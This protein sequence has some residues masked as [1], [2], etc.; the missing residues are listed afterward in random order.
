MNTGKF[1][2]ITFFVLLVFFVGCQYQENLKENQNSFF[3]LENVMNKGLSF[4]YKVDK[5][6][7]IS[8]FNGSSNDVIAE[9]VDGNLKITHYLDYACCAK[10]NV[11]IKT[12]SEKINIYY[13]NVGGMCRSK[14]IYPVEMIIENLSKGTYTVKIHGVEYQDNQI[15]E[16][17]R[18]VYLFDQESGW[19]ILNINLKAQSCLDAGGR[20]VSEY[21]DE[22][23]LEIC[24]FDGFRCSLDEIESCLERKKEQTISE[25]TE[26]ISENIELE[27]MEFCGHSTF[28]RCEKDE[29]CIVSGCSNEICQSINEESKISACIWKDCFRSE[30]YG[31]KCIN[32]E[33]QWIKKEE[34][35]SKQMQTPEEWFYCETADDC[36][37]VDCGCSCSG[38][39]GFS[40]DEVINKKY[41][42][43]WYMLK[44]CQKSKIC[45]MVCCPQRTIECVS[46]KC[47]V[48]EEPSRS[49][50]I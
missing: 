22:G 11:N 2:I 24:E 46:N 13:K 42:T 26:S 4:K 39:G 32:N 47:T 36:V 6:I 44:K 21:E 33:C 9:S 10:I 37:A 27:N 30:G 3:H 43:E 17:H 19:H 31:C 29:D 40:Y 20:I 34:I 5:E 35:S 38:C 1:F 45:P 7:P 18:L 48:I 41:E 23:V 50:L 12:Q 25:N 8:S 15:S 49:V 28:G 14:C 16:L